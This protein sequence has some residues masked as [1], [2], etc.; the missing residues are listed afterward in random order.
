[1]DLFKIDFF[2][3]KLNSFNFAFA[4]LPG[5]RQQA[6]EVI[7]AARRPRAVSV[8]VITYQPKSLSFTF[9]AK[10]MNSRAL[11]PVVF[12]ADDEATSVDL[13]TRLRIIVRVAGALSAHQQLIGETGAGQLAIF[14]LEQYDQRPVPLDRLPIFILCGFVFDQGHRKIEQRIAIQITLHLR[15]HFPTWWSE[16]TNVL[17]NSGNQRFVDGGARALG[18]TERS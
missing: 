1:M 4:A 7:I 14:I 17:T 5:N 12:L 18:R 2:D 8:E 11:V 3:R 13:H 15:F 16:L 10:V 9:I 6:R